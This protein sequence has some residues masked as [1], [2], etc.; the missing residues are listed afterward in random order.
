VAGFEVTGD[1]ASTSKL[2]SGALSVVRV[3]QLTR[4][5][6]RRRYTDLQWKR[7]QNASLHPIII[8]RLKHVD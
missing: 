1:S 7:Q 6:M 3:H 4:K 8:N 2:N 5:R